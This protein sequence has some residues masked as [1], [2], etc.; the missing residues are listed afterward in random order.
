MSNGLGIPL[1]FLTGTGTD[2]STSRSYRTILVLG[3][4]SAVGANAIQFLRMSLPQNPT[5]DQV[6]QKRSRVNRPTTHVKGGIKVDSAKVPIGPNLEHCDE[7]ITLDCLRALYNISYTPVATD[8]N[9]FGIRE[10]A[11]SRV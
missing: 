11:T 10:S 6:L 8:K 7:Q 2:T 4:S 3:G 9:T 1:P 5:P